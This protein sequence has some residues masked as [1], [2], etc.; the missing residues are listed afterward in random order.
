MEDQLLTKLF[1]TVEHYN[2]SDIHLM[3]DEYPYL[4]IKKSI[5]EA[6]VGEKLTEQAIEQMLS[7]TLSEEVM[8]RYREHGYAD[9]AYETEIVVE[10]E[11]RRV[12]YRIQLYKCRGKMTAAMRRI[13]LQVPSFE[14]LNLPPVYE[15]ALTMRPKGIIIIGGET[16]SGKSTTLATMINYINQ[17]HAKHIVT[18]EDPIEYIFKNVRSRINQREL[19]EDF[20]SFPEALRAVVREDPDI[21]VI[22]EIRDAETVRTAITA[23]EVGHL[24]LTSLHTTDSSQTFYRILN[25]FPPDEKDAVRQ[26]LGAT[27]V[28]IL[29]Q[30]L[31]PCVKE[32]VA[33]VPA[34]EV[35]INNAVVRMYIER[36]EENKLADLVASGQ[37]GMHDFNSSLRRL[38]FDEMIDKETA[39]RASLNPN[40]LE[41]M[42]SEHGK[43]S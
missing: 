26:N 14:E 31:L 33:V 19:G 27:L 21:I 41:T 30:M 39:M 13:K 9:Y 18:V 8:S 42:I 22:G 11:P 43:K 15:T 37:D 5:R 40:K 20:V 29:N 36:K 12:R 17:R 10:G 3:T 35:L 2:A 23:A 4:R 24:V 25:F 32:G 16:G 6:K 1:H 34:T 28:A 38:L 7:P